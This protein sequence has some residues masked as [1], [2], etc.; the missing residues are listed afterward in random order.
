[1]RTLSIGQ[2]NIDIYEQSAKAESIVYL[3]ADSAEGAEPVI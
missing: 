1:M 3:H 2:Y